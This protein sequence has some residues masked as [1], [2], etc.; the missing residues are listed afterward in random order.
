MLLLQLQKCT[1]GTA[2]W[3]EK[4]ASISGDQRWHRNNLGLKETQIKWEAWCEGNVAW[5]WEVSRLCSAVW[6]IPLGAFRTYHEKLKW[7]EH[8]FSVDSSL[9]KNVYYC[10]CYR[11]Y[12][13][14][15]T[16]KKGAIM[17]YLSVTQWSEARRVLNV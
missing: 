3:K 12:R 2:I 1:E 8:T 10:N 11:R 9:Q 6:S 5:H 4:T 15:I 17:F 16:R 14:Y 7:S 13:N